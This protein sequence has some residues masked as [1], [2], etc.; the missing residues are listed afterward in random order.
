MRK[1]NKDLSLV[2]IYE[3]QKLSDSL[4]MEIVSIAYEVRKNLMNEEFRNGVLNPSS[5]GKTQIAW[6]KFQTIHYELLHINKSDW[7]STEELKNISKDNKA[8]NQDSASVS[9]AEQCLEISSTEWANIYDFLKTNNYYS[10]PKGLKILEKLSSNNDQIIAKLIFP[11]DFELA[12]Y[13]KNKA[14]DFGYLFEALK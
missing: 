5:F 4:K 2:R 14:S 3:A 1:E 11:E 13:L 6:K 12:L 9:L 8:L 10:D 7:I